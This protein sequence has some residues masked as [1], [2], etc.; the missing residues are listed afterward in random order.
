MDSLG[1]DAAKLHGRLRAPVGLDIGGR[2]PESI[3]LSI[4]SEVHAAL[5]GHTGQPFSEAVNSVHA[6]KRALD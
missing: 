2:T 6:M 4:V 5:T 3:A 1:A